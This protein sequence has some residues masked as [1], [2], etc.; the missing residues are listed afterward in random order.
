MVE[1]KVL[2]K[3]RNNLLEREEAECLVNFEQGT[4]KKDELRT[5]IAKSLTATP[6]LTYINRFVVRAGAKQGKASVYV[7]DSKESMGR[8]VKESPKKE[9]KA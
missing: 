8:F 1:I 6:D 7:Y 4:P 3:K 9:K 5:A 2:N